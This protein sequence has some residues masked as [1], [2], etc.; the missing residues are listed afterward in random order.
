MTSPPWSPAKRP[1]E[2]RKIPADFGKQAFAHE[3][4]CDYADEKGTPTW[5]KA[6]PHMRYAM[7]YEN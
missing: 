4:L 3:Q 2:A 6:L 1:I 7:R 5:I